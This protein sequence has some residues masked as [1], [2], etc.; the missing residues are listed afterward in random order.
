MASSLSHLYVTLPLNLETVIMKED[1]SLTGTATESNS[2][3]LGPDDSMTTKFLLGRYQ[4]YCL[5]DG[6]RWSVH[7]CRV[8]EGDAQLTVLCKSSLGKW[9]LT[10]PSPYVA[11]PGS[12]VKRGPEPLPLLLHQTNLTRMFLLYF[13]VNFC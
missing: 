3:L 9:L 4:A 11:A 12:V 7:R 13:K 6:I 2:C 5:P 1:K 8:S 10:R